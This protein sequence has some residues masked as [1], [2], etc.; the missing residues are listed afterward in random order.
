MCAAIIDLDWLG[1]LTRPPRSGSYEGLIAA[2][3]E[4][5]LPNLA[6]AGVTHL[7]L[8]RAM[9]ERAA[10]DSLRS[11]L[12]GLVV[13]RVDARPDTIAQRLGARD[14]GDVLEGH[15]RETAELERELDRV[16]GEDAR[17]A[18]D[19]RPIRQVSQDLL[20]LLGWGSSEH[21]RRP[22]GEGIA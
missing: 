16:G 18:N 5:L 12:P 1:W 4:A 9:V 10:L 2:N 15:L 13:V 14:T 8:A 19:D 11:L 21:D 17:V 7:V 6:D 3:L 20:H 22:G